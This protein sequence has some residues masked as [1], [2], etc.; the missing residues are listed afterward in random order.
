MKTNFEFNF[1]AGKTRDQFMSLEIKV[2]DQ[3][4]MPITV[5]EKFTTNITIDLPA[6]IEFHLIGRDRNDTIVEDNKIIADKFISLDSL[7]I[8]GFSVDGW[9]LP[10]EFF[11]LIVDKHTTT[12]GNYWN[13][14]GVAKLIIDE[15]DP[16]LWLL[17]CPKI[18]S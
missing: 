17:E 16:V 5:T 12:F 13:N 9:Q 11:K 8:D 15:D 10:N 18:T 14:N 3:L 1:S 2:K 4:S 6:E 7:N